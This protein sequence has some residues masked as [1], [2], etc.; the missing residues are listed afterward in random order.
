[1]VGVAHAPGAGRYVVTSATVRPQLQSAADGHSANMWLQCLAATL[2]IAAAASR[3]VF[4]NTFL[5]RFKRSVQHD[6]AHQLALRHG[7]DSLGPLSL[8]VYFEKL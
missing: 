5:V 6:E 8:S 7:F 4:T 3:E 2:F 1:M